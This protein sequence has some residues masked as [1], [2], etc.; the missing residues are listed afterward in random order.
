MEKPIPIMINSRCPIASQVM[1]HFFSLAILLSFVLH[2]G[3]AEAALIARYTF[4]NAGNLGA[5]SQGFAHGTVNGTVNAFTDA[6]RGAVAQFNGGSSGHIYSTIGSLPGSGFTLTAWVKSG[7]WS[8]NRGV[9]QA[10]NGVG[11]TVNTTTKVIGGWV[12][13]TGIAWGR[14]IDSSGAK[15]M[16]QSGP[17]LTTGGSASWHFLAYR[18]NGSTYEVFIDGSNVGTASIAYNGTLA[19]HDTLILGRQ[20]NE[21]WSGLIDDFRVYD[22]ALSNVEIQNLAIPEPLSCF[23]FGWFGLFALLRRRR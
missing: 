10:Q 18:G 4:D 15:T 9:F 1:K 8:N 22:H 13:N 5:D 23:L 7:S 12:G 6:E 21:A 2:H 20:G 17:A 19:A 11:T 16:P 14:V 3:V